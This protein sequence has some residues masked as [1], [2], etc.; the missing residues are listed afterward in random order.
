VKRPILFILFSCFIS[1]SLFLTACQGGTGGQFMA[2]QVA[3]N[4]CNYGG[5]ISRIRAL[6]E[7]QVQFSLCYPDPA[8]TSKIANPVFSIQKKDILDATSGNSESLSTNVVGTGPYLMSDVSRPNQ[9]IFEANPDYW[10]TPPRS[11][12][13]VMSWVNSPFQRTV[14][15]N[16][17][18][19]DVIDSPD[20]SQ[21]SFIQNE[22]N[23]ELDYRPS[24]NIYYIGFNNS[25]PPFDNVNVRKAFSQAIDR[26]YIIDNY[27]PIGTDIADQFI[28]VTISPGFSSGLRW[29]ESNAT[30]ARN[31]LEQAGFDF[32]QTVRFYFDTTYS[33]YSPSPI[34]TA[35]YIREV[36]GGIGVQVTLRRMNT[37]EF[38]EAF[39]DGSMG[40]FMTSFQASYPDATNFYN[41]NFL[42][43]NKALGTPYP[44]LATEIEAAGKEVD[45]DVRQ[46]HYDQ[47]NQF[48][49]D[50]VPVIPLAYVKTTLANRVGIENVV[51]GS[52]FEDFTG[53]G[54]ITN[55]ITFVQQNQPQSYWPGDESD[56]DTLRIA[57]LVY[58]TLVKYDF[59]T[60]E[61]KPSLSSYWTSNKDATV[62]TFDL[63]YGVKFSNG[64]TLNAND[65]V[66]SFSTL[67]DAQSPNHVG[68]TGEFKIFKEFFGNFLNNPA[69]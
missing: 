62:W 25:V 2:L 41:S 60:N 15:L 23:L 19:V 21:Y 24:L 37:N 69:Q 44:D 63:R 56:L 67:W 29:S 57:T 66:A 68:R 40:F 11:D 16:N 39:S 61:V 32:S 48:I 36:F 26:K 50:L 22:A 12:L 10:G 3:A 5:E 4:N 7:F 6:N 42:G 38:Q 47:V 55:A 59:L 54:S 65:V 17:K 58:D 51:A 43:A 27:F 31:A 1:S 46:G 45:R 52:F 20:P 18:L 13:L 28:P 8:F 49:K 9:I 14:M 33:K 64:E 34:D 53:M 30:V 35:N